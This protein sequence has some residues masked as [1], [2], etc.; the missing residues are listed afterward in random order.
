[1]QD[2]QQPKRAK[3]T[4]L[5]YG[6]LTAAL[7]MTMALC[8]CVGSVR[9]SLSDTLRLLWNSL[10]GRPLPEGVSANIILNVRL[11]R[12]LCVTL[13]GAALSLCGAAM[14]GLL[15]NP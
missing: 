10:W 11:P 7:L 13:S 9:I 12:V 6:L 14:Q 4:P 5:T 8:V 3:F 1:M 15:R 2:L